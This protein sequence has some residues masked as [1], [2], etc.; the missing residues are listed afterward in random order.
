MKMKIVDLTSLT[1]QNFN[2]TSTF[3]HRSDQPVGSS[4]ELISLLVVSCV[5]FMLS[6]LINVQ[7]NSDENLNP[8]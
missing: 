8:I 5:K 4:E 2:P 3:P 7:L 6:C 1:L